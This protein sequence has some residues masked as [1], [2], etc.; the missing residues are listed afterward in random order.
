VPERAD[1]PGLVELIA[2]DETR[3]FL[4]RARPDEAG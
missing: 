3:R 4:G 2:A 1:L